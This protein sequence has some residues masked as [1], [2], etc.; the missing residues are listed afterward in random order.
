[1][2]R[3][4][5]MSALSAASEQLK[6]VRIGSKGELTGVISRRANTTTTYI[7]RDEI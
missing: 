1:M 4:Q 3:F 7:S 2:A 6:L 5:L